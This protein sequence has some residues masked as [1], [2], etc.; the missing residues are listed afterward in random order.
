MNSI[1][2]KM[3]FE[4]DWEGDELTKKYYCFRKLHRMRILA[5]PFWNHKLGPLRRGFSCS[6]V[7]PHLDLVN[8]KLPTY[9]YF[10]F[11]YIL[12]LIRKRG[13]RVTYMQ[14][15]FQ[16]FGLRNKHIKNYTWNIIWHQQ[17]SLAW[18]QV[19]RYDQGN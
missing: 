14:I 7:P 10:A 17:Q 15:W 6:N 11:F 1:A 13:I 9:F 18:S 8:F 3:D 19:L 12:Y 4:Q 16:H 5:W 2:S